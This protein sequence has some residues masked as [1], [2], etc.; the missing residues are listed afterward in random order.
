M[1]VFVTPPRHNGSMRYSVTCH[2]CG[3]TWQ[4]TSV[5]GSTKCGSC[6]TPIYVPLAVR[7]AASGRWVSQRQLTT[8]ART[9][10]AAP[11]VTTVVVRPARDLAPPSVREARRSQPVGLTWLDVVSRL[12]ESLAA[13]R[14]RMDAPLSSSGSR[15]HPLTWPTLSQAALPNPETAPDPAY[16][17][18]CPCGLVQPCPLPGCR[19]PS[20]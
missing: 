5:T 3:A 15:N 8:A 7:Q 6:R 11:A 1:T 20:G 10:V 17:R 9:P 14:A 2:A 16:R 12:V 18:P 19:H 13:N 4:S